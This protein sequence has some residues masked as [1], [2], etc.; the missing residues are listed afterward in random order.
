MLP[1]SQAARLSDEGAA[2]MRYGPEFVEE[3]CAHIAQGGTVRQFCA[4]PGTPDKATIFRWLA[5]HEDFATAYGLALT[6]KAD[7]F[8]EE[9]I[10]AADSNIDPAKVR[11]MLSTRMWL[12][13]RLKPR[14]YGAKQSLEH[15]G[16]VKTVVEIVNF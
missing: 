16:E 9:M 6:W 5:K 3:F 11:N 8:A 10:D 1:V 14:R 7:A 15:S 2:A 12:A 4:L 13:E